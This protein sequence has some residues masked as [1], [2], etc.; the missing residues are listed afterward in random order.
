M[1]DKLV[2]IFGGGGFVGRYVAQELL[3]AGARVRIAERDPSNAMRVKP[4][5]GLGQTQ[6]FSADVTKPDSVR[7]AVQGAD[8]VINLV[9]ILSGA[10]DKVHAEGAANVAKA[11]AL[12][13]AGALVHVSAIGADTGSASAYGRTKG[14][15][16]EAVKAAFAGAA[17][18]R[19]S[20][21]FGREDQFLNR[22]ADLIR[23][24]PV[25][26][27]VS[28]ET[29]FQPVYV[30]DVAKAIAKAA[31][32]PAAY[33][34]KTYE[35]GG[36]ETLSMLEINQKI[37]SMTGRDRSFVPVP[38]MAAKLLSLVPGGPMTGDQLKMLAKDNVASDAMPGLEAFGVNPTPMA[39]VADRWLVQYRRHGRFAATA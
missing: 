7:A 36:A 19:P 38:A 14:E 37:A 20:I 21:I 12:A 9:G 1:T 10:F 5:G 30:V 24:A 3:A 32:D 8:A 17:I 6:F 4:L 22:F 28:G 33:A 26:P 39:A 25:V 23:L 2:T 15:G 27:V 31:L 11:A 29:K 16:E 13:G 18:L 35:L 34:G